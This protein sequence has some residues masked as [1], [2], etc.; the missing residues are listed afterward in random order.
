MT[1]GVKYSE[2]Y[3]D[4]NADIWL[5]SAAASPL[6]KPEGYD[7]PNGYWEYLQQ[8][9]PEG[10]HGD[11]FHYKTIN[12]DMLGWMI[13]RVTGKSVTE[14]ASERLWRRM[15][16]EQDAYQTGRRQGCALRGWRHHRGPARPGSAGAAYAG[17]RGCCRRRRDCSRRRL[18]RR[19]R[20][21]VTGPN[22]VAS[23]RSPMAATPANAGSSIT[24]TAPLRPAAFMARRSMSIRQRKWCWCALRL[25]RAPKTVSSTLRRLPAYQAVADFLMARN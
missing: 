20:P 10:S 11:E 6:P 7:G 16:V 14:L 2:N 24:T 4:P 9:Q 17:R 18:W 12:S 8:V 19:L 22:S 3:S 25:S 15:G 13:S 23:Q 5:Y 21:A 1:T